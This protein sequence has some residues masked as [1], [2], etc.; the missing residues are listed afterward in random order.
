MC[1]SVWQVPGD[2]GQNWVLAPTFVVDIHLPEVAVM[3][4]MYIR[5][6]CVLFVFVCVSIDVIFYLFFVGFSVVLGLSSVF[7]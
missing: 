5:I 7:R 6:E 1:V 3:H 4:I 2:E